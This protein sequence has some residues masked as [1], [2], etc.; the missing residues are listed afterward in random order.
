[1]SY[2]E[3]RRAGPEEGLEQREGKSHVMEQASDSHRPAQDKSQ[4]K[5]RISTLHP[6]WREAA[7][8]TLGQG[9]QLDNSSTAIISWEALLKQTQREAPAEP[10]RETYP[11]RMHHA[12]GRARGPR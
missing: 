12:L 8:W 9:V 11:G 4:C 6:T 2:G 1:M 5:C 3:S 10:S 7:R